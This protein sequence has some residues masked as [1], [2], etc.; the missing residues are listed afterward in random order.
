MSRPGD[1][2]Q[3]PQPKRRWLNIGPGI[4]LALAISALIG[5]RYVATEIAARRQSSAPPIIERRVISSSY[6][7]KSGPTPEVSF[8]IDRA[9]K[10]NVTAAQM[11]RLK[12]L[13]QKWQK[14]SGPKIAQANEAAART[15]EYM[16]DAKGNRRTPVAQI[17]SAAAPVIALS[18]EISAARRSYWSQAVS[19]L[20]P[21]QRK[22][23]QAEREAAWAQR[24]RALS[25]EP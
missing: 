15:N 4:I 11:A 7:E 2:Q 13:Q 9:G 1:I 6:E 5:A 10:L 3:S 19:I 23:L 18:G 20:N 12:A 16:T 21:A 22:A 14:H 24:T 8:V 25:S 17:Q